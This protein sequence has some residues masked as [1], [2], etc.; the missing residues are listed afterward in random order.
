[1]L[2]IGRPEHHTWIIGVPGILGALSIWG[3]QVKS[4]MGRAPGLGL[5]RGEL[6]LAMQPIVPRGDKP[7]E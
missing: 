3:S 2:F 1:M 7:N 4:G 5:L 6:G